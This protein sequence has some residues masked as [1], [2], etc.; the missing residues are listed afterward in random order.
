MQDNIT[1]A[2]IHSPLVGPFTWQLV[3]QAMVDQGLKAVLPA[4]LDDPNSAL[5]Y[6]QQQ[7]DSVAR[8]LSQIS[9]N[10]AI[11]FVAHSGAG[12]LLPAIRQNWYSTRTQS[13]RIDEI[14]RPT[15]GRAIPQISF[16]R[17]IIS[18][19]DRR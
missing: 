11:V 6:W 4:L 16:K 8:E 12:P 19:V 2:L 14:G 15:M 10:D 13:N 17:R 1:Y 3:Y 7:A 18:N 9:I 5:P